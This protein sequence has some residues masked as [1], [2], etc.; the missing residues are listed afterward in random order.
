MCRDGGDVKNRIER[1]Y[2]MGKLK[3]KT[4]VTVANITIELLF[5]GLFQVSKYSFMT[6]LHAYIPQDRLRALAHGETLPDRTSGSALFADISV[7]TA[8]T[9]GLRESLRPRLGAEELT[10]HLDEF[11]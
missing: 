8:L 4:T 2:V 9:E 11:D 5:V 3:S 6:T 7:F 10:R 1:A